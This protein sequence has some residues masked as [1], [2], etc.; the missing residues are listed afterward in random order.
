MLKS[1]LIDSIAKKLNHISV[2]EISNSV[3]VLI[4]TMRSALS[5]SARIEI[6]GF[7]SFA[8]HYQAPH[9]ARNPKTGKQVI[10][11]GKNRPHFKPG[12]K[13]RE[14]VDASLPSPGTE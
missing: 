7:G 10:T 14:R 12:K 9:T 5:R 13:L 11:K 1:E 8:L 2:H 3:N 4:E 6:R